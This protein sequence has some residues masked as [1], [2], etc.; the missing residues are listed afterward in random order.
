MTY[1]IPTPSTGSL[2]LPREHLL[3]PDIRPILPAL[4]ST[5]LLNWH[6]F[7]EAVL[8]LLHRVTTYMWTMDEHEAPVHARDYCFVVGRE[9]GHQIIHECIAADFLKTNWSYQT[10]VSARRF[11][12][13]EYLKLFDVRRVEASAWLT[14][15]IR[16]LREKHTNETLCSSPVMLALYRDLGRFSL[17]GDF[18]ATLLALAQKKPAA[19]PFY[20]LQVDRFVNRQVF[21]TRPSGARLYHAV[22]SLTRELRRHLRADGRPC[23]EAD[24]S[25]CFPTLLSTFYISHCAEWTKFVGFVR[26]D[27]YSC[28]LPTV[29]ALSGKAITRDELKT[30]WMIEMFGQDY[31]RRHVWA[32]M[33][34]EFPRL[35][36]QVERVRKD[37]YR[38]LSRRL[39]KI[40]SKLVLDTAVPLIK[41]A[42]PTIPIST[43]HDCLVCP[44][45][46][47]DPV[48]DILR[49]TFGKV[50]G[51]EPMVKTKAHADIGE[52]FTARTDSAAVVKISD[53]PVVAQPRLG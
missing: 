38:N 3:A 37:N 6:R 36:E 43:V 52:E 32:A 25:A 41:A 33:P 12:P 50:L 23:G 44:L 51:F 5:E 17:G 7:D 13:T 22:S 9:F 46:A 35:C 20:R 31:Q 10:D 48:A 53:V 45:D 26:T 29:M 15:K 30:Q 49:A 42:L 11:R 47:L 19:A 40:E 27:F 1:P 34:R 16:L 28:L 24:I 21:F 39:Q 14:N 2:V 8:Y 4:F 18:E